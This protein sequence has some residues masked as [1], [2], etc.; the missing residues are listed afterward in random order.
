MLSRLYPVLK[1]IKMA[2]IR[3]KEKTHFM[4]Y[5]S[6]ILLTLQNATLALSLRYGRTRSEKKDL[7]YSSTGK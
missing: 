3:I 2:V 4:K 1:S 7:F 6:L 5:V